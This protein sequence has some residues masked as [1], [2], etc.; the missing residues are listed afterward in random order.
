MEFLTEASQSRE[1]ICELHLDYSTEAKVLG[2]LKAARS[3]EKQAFECQMKYK[4]ILCVSQARSGTTTCL[5]KNEW[6]LAKMP[7]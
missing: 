5:N 1:A 2:L 7:H 6:R 3:H 4:K